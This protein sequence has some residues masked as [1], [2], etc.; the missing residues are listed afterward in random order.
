MFYLSIYQRLIFLY[1]NN[2]IFLLID[3][4]NSI[5]FRKKVKN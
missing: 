2:Q 3:S 4:I 1:I 5:N